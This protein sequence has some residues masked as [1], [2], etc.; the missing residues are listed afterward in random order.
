[1]LLPSGA[2]GAKHRLTTYV[3]EVPQLECAY[4]GTLVHMPGQSSALEVER[5]QTG[6]R[7]EKRLL[8]VLKALAEL[9]D[10]SLGDLL[11]GIVLHAFEGKAPFSPRTLKEIKQLK[12][13]YGLTL[14]ASNSHNLKERQ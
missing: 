2:A 1:M 12:A 3:S 11:E 10:L 6:V 8:K 14:Q 13:I 9:K 4:L 7:I 5:M